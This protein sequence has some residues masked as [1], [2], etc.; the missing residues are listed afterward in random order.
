VRIVCFQDIV[1]DSE[2]QYFVGSKSYVLM[3][4]LLIEDVPVSL[5]MG[6]TTESP[7]K[8]QDK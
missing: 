1:D 8:T 6:R 2:S 5:S 7:Q 4:M 3:G